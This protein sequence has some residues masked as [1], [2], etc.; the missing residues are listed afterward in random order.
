MT[1]RPPTL[2]PLPPLEGR[3]LVT[4]IVPS[5]NQG[6][7]IGETLD[8]ILSQSHRPLEILVIDG[9]SEDETVDV[10]KSYDS[11]PELRWWSE[12]DSGV[13]EAINKGFER[14]R[15]VV[16]AIQSADDFYLPGAIAAAVGRL[17][18]DPAVGLVYGD[19][20]RVD[21][22]GNELS[23]FRTGSFSIE[24][25]LSKAT[26]VLQPAAFFRLELAGQ[27]GGWDN[28]FFNADT[29]F[30]LRM[31]FQTKA[32]KIS[33]FMSKRRM[34]SGQRDAE[35]ERIVES[36]WRMMET[37]P[38]IAAG[39]RRYKRAAR[40]GKHLHAIRYDRSRGA[41]RRR[42]HAWC[43][44]LAYPPV[45]R[46]RF[47]LPLMLP[48]YFVAARLIGCARRLLGAKR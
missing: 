41:G 8:S 44:A 10:L 32:E 16:G 30:W 9:A 20:I 12:P 25:F 2:P 6:R 14:A 36:Y 1:A 17:M 42:Y 22:A 7:F 48:G 40:C 38:D 43:A 34:H 23:R 24:N 28:R 11:A 39:P 47:M 4:I 19:C 37:S 35:A 45:V 5:Y 3:P 27:L 29:E 18:I 33:R 21:E 31:I 46:R 15:G 13:V 26:V